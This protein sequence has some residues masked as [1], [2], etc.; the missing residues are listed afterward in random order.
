MFLVSLNDKTGPRTLLLMRI[1]GR[2]SALKQPIPS[3]VVV[4]PFGPSKTS[5]VLTGVLVHDK[6]RR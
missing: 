3:Q 1:Q 4:D 6:S 5:A 2:R